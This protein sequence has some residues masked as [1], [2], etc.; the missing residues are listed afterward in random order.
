MFETH[1][2]TT[3]TGTAYNLPFV[4]AVLTGTMHAHIHVHCTGAERRIALRAT[5][6]CPN[7]DPTSFYSSFALY[8]VLLYSFQN[9]P[10]Q[11]TTNLLAAGVVPQASRVIRLVLNLRYELSAKSMQKRRIQDLVHNLALSS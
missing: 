2:V 5:I 4:A 6:N 11:S 9:R 1:L 8:L 7:Q 10:P 3:L